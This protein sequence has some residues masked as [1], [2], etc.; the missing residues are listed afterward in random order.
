MR[1]ALCTCALLLLV[2]CATALLFD[3]L[4]WVDVQAQVLVYGKLF[5]RD[6]DALKANDSYH[7]PYLDGYQQLN[8]TVCGKLLGQ[9]SEG[10]RIIGCNVEK[11]ENL[12]IGVFAFCNI[13]VAAK[14][15]PID[16]GR[17]NT[18]YALTQLF[19]QVEWMGYRN[20]K[21]PVSIMQYRYMGHGSTPYSPEDLTYRWLDDDKLLLVFDESRFG[22]IRPIKFLVTIKSSDKNSSLQRKV[23]Y[24]D[25]THV[26]RGLH[27]KF[28]YSISIEAVNFVGKS[29]PAQMQVG[30]LASTGI[31]YNTISIMSI[32]FL[33]TRL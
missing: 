33:I 28:N 23:F 10:V 5:D 4:T 31:C 6:G 17:E 12:D 19:N 15:G 29:H 26:L 25:G 20:R 18:E 13:L 1:L 24:E 8:M 7:S 3:S 16:L 2:S 21:S 30:S 32:A 27:P 11:V 9:E 14:R 22:D